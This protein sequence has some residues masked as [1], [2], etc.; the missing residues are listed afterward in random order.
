MIHIAKWFFLTGTPLRPLPHPES[1]PHYALHG[2]GHLIQGVTLPSQGCEHG[3][4][5]WQ[6]VQNLASPIL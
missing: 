4:T 2:P 1:H 5:F 6:R 3:V